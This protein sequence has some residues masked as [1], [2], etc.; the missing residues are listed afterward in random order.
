MEIKTLELK[1]SQIKP[2]PE[3]PRVIKDHKFKQLVKSVTD[4]P[5]MLSIRDVVIDE[6]NMILGGNMRYRAC[7]TL[8]WTKVP[9]M[10]VTLPEEKRKELIIKDNISY[11]EWDDD[12]IEQSWDTD[13]FNKWIG[14]ETFD[15]SALDYADLTQDMEDMSNGVKKA[16][17]IDFGARFIEAKELEKEARTRGLNIGNIFLQALK[18]FGK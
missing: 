3:N 17:Q 8:G 6:N 12:V 16:I 9:V 4:F 7:R 2:N 5:E 1:I 10:V 13:L 14:R 11:G 18:N 15:Y